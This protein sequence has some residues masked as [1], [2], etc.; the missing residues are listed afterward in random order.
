MKAWSKGKKKNEVAMVV[1]IA[2]R[3]TAFYEPDN[4][5]LNSMENALYYV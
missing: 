5:G 3:N 2:Y 4:W 1:C